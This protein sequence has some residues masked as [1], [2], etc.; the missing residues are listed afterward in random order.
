M[1]NVFRGKDEK[2]SFRLGE[3]TGVNNFSDKMV[4]INIT[5]E[6]TQ[7]GPSA[8]ECKCI[9]CVCV[10]VGENES[11]CVCVEREPMAFS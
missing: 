11:E 6:T 3:K 2:V 8:R 7:P 9:A 5:K 1:K 4:L 10:C